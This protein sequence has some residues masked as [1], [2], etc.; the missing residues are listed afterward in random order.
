MTKGAKGVWEITVEGDLE[1]H[2]YHYLHKVNGEWISV[3]DPYALSSTANSGDSYV[4][5]P[6]KLHKIRRAKT[7]RPISQAIIYEMSVRDFSWQKKLVSSI[8]VN[9]SA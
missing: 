4:I 2:S 6:D 7:Q 1:A 9:F 5:N 3:H 8:A